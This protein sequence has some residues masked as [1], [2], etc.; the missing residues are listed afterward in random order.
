[1]TS[2]GLQGNNMLL[3]LEV[4]AAWVIAI[5]DAPPVVASAAHSVGVLVGV[6]DPDEGIVAMG[7]LLVE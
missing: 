1:M 3:L 6:F 4:E 2:V 5:A 7:I